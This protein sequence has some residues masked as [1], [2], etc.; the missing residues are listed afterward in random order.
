MTGKNGLNGVFETTQR[1]I[2]AEF[3]GQVI[4]DSKRAMLMRESG[5]ELHY[6]F[7][8]ADVRMDLL[9][10]TDHITHSGYKGDA[11]H[12]TVKVG[13]REAENAAWAY[14]EVKE[15]RPDMRGYVAFGWK[16]MDHWYEED[17]EVFVH[18]R[19]PYHR[20]DTILSSRHIRVVVNGETIAETHRPHLLFE[21]GL[22]T[23]YYIPQEDI[24]MDLLTPTE[25]HTACPY[26]GTASYWSIK[27][28]NQVYKDLVWGY[29]DPIPETPKIKG[30]LAFYNE[31]L[32]IYVDGELEGKPRTVWS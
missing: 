6:Y 16:A 5:H 15:G 22:P 4:A 25:T 18:P 27:A 24:R 23:R 8:E 30:L 19:D 31:K 3:G 7:P 9:V 20:V 17:E 26:K 2:R 11:H 29:L 1:R 21:T 13:E 14:P 32:D 10:A 28:S 12:W